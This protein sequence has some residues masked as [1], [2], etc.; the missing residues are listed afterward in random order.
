MVMIQL[1][2]QLRA[3]NRYLGFKA[4]VLE[5][6]DLYPGKVSLEIYLSSFE[7]LLQT[8]FYTIKIFY[9]LKCLGDQSVL[10]LPEGKRVQVK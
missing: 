4:V 9:V 7:E 3:E 6:S 1:S 5:S 8:E 2:L 10:A